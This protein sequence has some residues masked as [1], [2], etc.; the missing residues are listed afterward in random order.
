MNG[1]W[2][3]KGAVKEISNL[4]NYEVSRTLRLMNDLIVIPN[5]L[6]THY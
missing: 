5:Q 6:C 4:E 3:R 2:C 1:I